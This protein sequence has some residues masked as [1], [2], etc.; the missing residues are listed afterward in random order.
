MSEKDVGA[1]AEVTNIDGNST[2]ARHISPEESEI[3]HGDKV[4]DVSLG[5]TVTSDS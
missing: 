3:S 1:T 2:A 5:H 4:F